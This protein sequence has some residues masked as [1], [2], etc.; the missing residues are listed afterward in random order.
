MTFN[1]IKD[2]FEL[3]SLLFIMLKNMP[4]KDYKYNNRCILN[5]LNVYV[6]TLDTCL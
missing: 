4:R 1:N 2:Y 6:V 3:L 5:N